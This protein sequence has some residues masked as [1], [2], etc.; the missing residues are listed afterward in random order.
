M[1]DLRKTARTN[2]S[3]FTEFHVAEMMLGH[4]IPRVYDYHDYLEEQRA[5]Y[6]AWARYLS[7]S[8]SSS[9]SMTSLTT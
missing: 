8:C 3:R 6:Q 1:H 5:A 7:L 9:Q 2:F 4:A